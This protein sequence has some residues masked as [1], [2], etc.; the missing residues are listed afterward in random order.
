MDS[1]P[2]GSVVV[3]M[4]GTVRLVS[5]RECP[6]V[7]DWVGG[8]MGEEAGLSGLTG[9]YWGGSEVRWEGGDEGGDEEDGEAECLT[10]GAGG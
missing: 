9:G 1:L 7:V 6:V 5:Q 3:C 2:P 10:S 8:R 4:G